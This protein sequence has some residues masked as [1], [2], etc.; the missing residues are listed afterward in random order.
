MNQNVDP[1]EASDNADWTRKQTLA[2][3]V[4]ITG[5]CILF[6]V[7]FRTAYTIIAVLCLILCVVE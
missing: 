2:Q 5:I 1:G 3:T 7:P 6:S 4:W